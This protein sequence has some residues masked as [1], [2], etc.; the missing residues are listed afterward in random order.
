MTRSVDEVN[1]ELWR[2]LSVLGYVGHMRQQIAWMTPPGP[3][4]TFVVE[5]VEHVGHGLRRIINSDPA[6]AA[7]KDLFV[8][9]AG[10]IDHRDLVVDT[11]EKRFFYQLGR[12]EVSS[13][14]EKAVE[15]YG[16]LA[17]GV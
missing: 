17:A 5:L 13:E 11:P 12:V 2:E 4:T 10:W 3:N 7:A 16:K 15:R 9:L 6:T 14:D 1:S 8:L